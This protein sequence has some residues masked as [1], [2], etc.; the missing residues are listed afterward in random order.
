MNTDS[1]HLH[2]C[3][4]R[5]LLEKPGEEAS[6]APGARISLLYPV[7]LSN[8]PVWSLLLAVCFALHWVCVQQYKWHPQG[9]PSACPKQH[10]II[11][12]LSSHEAQS[13][14]HPLC[15]FMGVLLIN[16]NSRGNIKPTILPLGP[17]ACLSDFFPDSY[18]DINSFSNLVFMVQK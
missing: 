18:P 1:S 17:F 3:R 9:L 13:H 7:T 5:A 8:A 14:F 12:G 11:V 4:H 15:P 16:S 6:P 10:L 2:A